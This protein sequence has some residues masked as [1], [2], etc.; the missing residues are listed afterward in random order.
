MEEG[1]QSKLNK[2]KM[3]QESYGRELPQRMEALQTV[4]QQVRDHPEQRRVIQELHRLIHN[5][6]GSAGT[7]GYA[8]LSEQARL[9]EHQLITWLQ[10]SIALTDQF[11]D[12]LLIQMTELVQE[13]MTKE[14]Q[15]PA[16]TWPLESP[17]PADNRLVCIIEDDE[18]MAEEVQAQLAIYGW[19]SCIFNNLDQ[20]RQELD[21]LTPAA[22]MVDIMLPEGIS[23]GTD[24]IQQLHRQQ[25]FQTPV[26]IIS[27][28]WD[29]ESRLGAA[30][31]GARAYMTKPIDFSLL[32]EQLDSLTRRNEGSPFQVLI[33]EDNNL[34]AEHYAAVL[35][36]AGMVAVTLEQPTLI[37]EKLES[38]TPELVLLD[39]Y[40]PECSGIEVARV[41]RQDNKFIDLPIVFL[42]TESGRQL[43][44]V[45]M[46]AGA[47]DFLQKPIK[48]KDLIAAVRQRCERFR[49]L[50][51]LIRQDR[52]TGLLNHIAFRLQLEFEMGRQQRLSS[53]L[54]VVML[55]IDHFKKV[56][57]SYGHPVGD[58]V[59]KSLAKLLSKRLRKTDIVGRYGGEE[60]GV[61]MPDTHPDD[62]MRVMNQLRQEFTQIIHIGQQTEFSCSFSAGVLAVKYNYSL[63][64]VL[65][66]A[67]EALYISKH[68]G[69]NCVTLYRGT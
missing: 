69:R 44:H 55:D 33:V 40:M 43:Q 37:L 16:I 28:R 34:L 59:I 56:N 11:Y 31:A 48:D 45:A 18:L 52:M 47:D 5:L 67:D 42:S 54:S 7:F 8:Q 21:K 14:V 4:F 6:A 39:L 27:S 13:S 66:Y 30:R 2:L 35:Q 32:I 53:L 22:L 19:Q 60:F 26:I 20:A 62:A 57:D 10:S 64:N 63:D 23:A 1:N 61:I 58:R 25:G 36:S 51:E 41:I 50:R 17:V 9:L 38:F 68:H 24:F 3:L 46:Q 12:S 29:W 65:Q 49:S 15:R